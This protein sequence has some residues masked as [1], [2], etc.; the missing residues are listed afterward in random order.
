MVPGVMKRQL[1]HEVF[2]IRDTKKKSL[3]RRTTIK[4]VLFDGDETARTKRG[5]STNRRL[6]PYSKSFNLYDNCL[7]VAQYGDFEKKIRVDIHNRNP[8]QGQKRDLSLSYESS[9]AGNLESNS[10]FINYS[11]SDFVTT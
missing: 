4:M 7:E 1:V 3:N 9:D 11:E 10:R 5:K 6:A 8:I 2:L